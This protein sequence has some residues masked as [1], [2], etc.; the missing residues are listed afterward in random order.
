MP[1]TPTLASVAVGT[2]T[3][4]PVGMVAAA[5]NLASS[6]GV[7]ALRA[8]GSAADAALAAGAVLAVT[9]QH[10]CGLGGDLFALVHRPGQ[11]VAALCAAGRA[12]SGADAGGP[13]REGLDRLP[14][15]GNILAVTVPG[16]VDGWTELHA[17]FG[18][19]PLARVLEA[20]IS[21]AERG[22][23]ASRLLAYTAGDILPLEGADDYRAAAV[24]GRL[25]AGALV[26]RPPVGA[27]LDAIAS[28]GRDAFYLGPFGAGLV[29]LGGG[30]YQ[31]EDLARTQA[32]WI[33]PLRITAWGHD[34]WTTPPPSQGYLTL[35]GAWISEGLPLPDEPGDAA[36]PHLLAEAARVAGTDRG[37]VLFEGADGDALLAPE[38][39]APRRAIID[40]RRRGAQAPLAS[41]G[42]TTVCC[43]VDG[44]RMGV[45]LIQS[46]ASAWGAH[47]VEPATRVFLHDRGIGFSL[48]P[49]HPAELAPG[50][51]P[52]H[53]LAPALVTRPD[54]SLR[55]VLGTKGAD[56]QPQVLLQLLARLLCGG[57]PPGR[58][59]AAPR[60]VL[61]GAGTFR[62]WDGDGPGY[63]ALEAHAEKAWDE[64]LARRGHEVR[65]SLDPVDDGFGHAQ[66][67]EVIDD[68]LAGVADP[69]ALDGAAVGY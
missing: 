28:G 45:T 16:C 20:A 64:G 57:E 31:P 65:R 32:E 59:V 69:R 21:Y 37:A 39:L 50:R 42:G 60:W 62:T 25:L 67:I 9:N 43:A 35:A 1:T 49:G 44:E 23:P 47:I 6:A 4:S 22:F 13:R 2:T 41:A 12:G 52:P 55:A 18:R 34:V 29:A 46:N 11:P 54:G 33:M 15:R 40:P 68:G 19:L 27:A 10:Q 17:R 30:L 58:A 61:G 14:L 7:A 38:R 63:V 8:G 66:V 26:R 5:D 56:S 3:R 48:E 51:R 53:T 24:D 36:W